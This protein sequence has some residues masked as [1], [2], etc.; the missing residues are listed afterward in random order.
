MSII[1]RHFEAFVG[2][3]AGVTMEPQAGGTVV[4]SVPAVALPPGWNRTAVAVKFILPAGY[5]QAAPDCFWTEP[6]L[7]LEHGGA[8][9]NT[10]QQAAPGIPP[11]WLWFS[12]H[13]A[14][15]QPNSDNM[16]TYLNVIRRR[17]GEVR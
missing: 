7:A 2:R 17:L 8:P 5:P 12:W 9:Q 4:V 13:P 3:Y 16:F 14:T 15:W 6:A 10:G 11:G 1:E